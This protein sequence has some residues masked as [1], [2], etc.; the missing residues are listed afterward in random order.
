MSEEG[1]RIAGMS[2]RLNAPLAKLLERIME[3]PFPDDAAPVEARASDA[4]RIE[5]ALRR[6][7]LEDADAPGGDVDLSDI[8]LSLADMH[9]QVDFLRNASAYCPVVRLAEAWIPFSLLHD[10]ENPL[11]DLASHLVRRG[12]GIIEPLP[13]SFVRPQR[14][15][16]LM[17]E[18]LASFMSFRWIRTI[19][20]TS[21]GAGNVEVSNNASGWT[22]LY[23]PPHLMAHNGFGGPSTPVFG[24]LPP[25][26]Y[27]FAI[28]NS[29][30]I[31]WDQ[32]SWPIPPT[33]N[34]QPPHS[35]HVPL[36]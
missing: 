1:D 17:V 19:F 14:V 13:F 18:P 24:Y 26:N 27:H 34:A 2:E 33:L 29:S 31:Q 35:I 25:G 5:A 30:S 20:G 23:S 16:G 10:E 7:A 28:K 8:A 4:G 3:H 36:P 15:A 11:T 6:V 22:I 9:R 12:E 32:T 21:S